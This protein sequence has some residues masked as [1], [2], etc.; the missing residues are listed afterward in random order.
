MGEKKAKNK[1][2]YSLSEVSRLAKLPS[3]TIEIWEKELY[4]LNAGRTS[5]G[6]TIFRKRDLDIILRLKDLLNKEGM[7]LAGAK[8]KIEREFNIRGSVP[9]HPDRLKK[10]LFQVKEQLADIAA[11]LEK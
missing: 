3:K 7:T 11:S 6:K 1:L 5:K 4:F 9:V 2:V 8:R 10:L